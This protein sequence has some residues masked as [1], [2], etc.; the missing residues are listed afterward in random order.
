[1]VCALQ[2]VKEQTSEICMEAVKNNGYALQY[3]KEQTPE[4][5]MEHDQSRQDTCIDDTTYSRSRTDIS[6]VLYDPENPIV[7]ARTF[8]HT[9]TDILP[10]SRITIDTIGS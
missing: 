10:P 8:K 3:V 7:N 4:I 9:Y 1:M 5:C 2:Y 6:Y